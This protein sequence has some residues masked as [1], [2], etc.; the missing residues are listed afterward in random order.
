MEHMSVERFLDIKL[1]ALATIAIL[2]KRLGNNISITQKD[3]DS[4]AYV[5]LQEH[6]NPEISKSSPD[7][8]K[9]TLEVTERTRN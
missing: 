2:V 4:V 5:N 8:H 1:N 3:L 6:W 9:L 7:A